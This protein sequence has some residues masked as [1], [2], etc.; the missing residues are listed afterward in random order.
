M[1]TSVT[2]KNLDP[3]ENLKT[4]IEE[5]L[6]RLDKLLYN[7]AEAKVVLLVEKFR[8]TAEIKTLRA[9]KRPVCSLS[10]VCCTRRESSLKSHIPSTSGTSLA[11][12]ANF[13]GCCSTSLIAA[14]L[15]WICAASPLDLPACV[16]ARSTSRPAGSNTV[17]LMPILSWCFRKLSLSRRK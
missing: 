16:D 11:K 1:Q 15:P 7:P 13:V 10:A 3:S 4:Y 2:F 17:L 9:P 6:D 14:S 8:H 12:V 5:K